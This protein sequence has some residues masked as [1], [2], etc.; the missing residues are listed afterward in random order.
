MSNHFTPSEFPTKATYLSH[1]MEPIIPKMGPKMLPDATFSDVEEQ[2]DILLIPRG[3]ILK[4][5]AGR[6]LE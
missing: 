1:S 4:Q 6:S 3:E 5:Y 2:F